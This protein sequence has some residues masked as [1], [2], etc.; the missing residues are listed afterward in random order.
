MSVPFKGAV[1][2][3]VVSTKGTEETNVEYL[4]RVCML[5]FEWLVPKEQ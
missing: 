5:E 1:D 3:N 4:A 2:I